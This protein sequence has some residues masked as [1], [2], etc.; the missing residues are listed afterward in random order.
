M[1]DRVAAFA[2]WAALAL[3]LFFALA[4]VTASAQGGP[5]IRVGF[6]D[7]D[8]VFRDSR[9][10]RASQQSLDAEVGRIN[11][12]LD[13]FTQQARSL[14]GEMDRAGAQLSATER[15]RRERELAALNA[16]F[17]QMKGGF[18][19]DYEAHRQEAVSAMV[20]K[21]QRAVEKLARDE[22]YDLVVNRAVA[23]GAGADLTEKLIRAL[24]SEAP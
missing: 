15:G 1:M 8:R 6:V 5:P 4:P 2:R 3:A 18:T 24:D 23:V 14:Q 9:T 11:G 21:I 13:K 17:E 16:R 19:E 10:G 12:E 20:A 7:F 22:G